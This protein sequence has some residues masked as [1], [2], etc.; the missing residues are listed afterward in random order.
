MVG[1]EAGDPLVS[2]KDGKKAGKQT[3]AGQEH[4]DTKA[5]KGS[6]TGGEELKNPVPPEKQEQNNYFAS[7]RL[8]RK[9]ARDSALSLLQDAASKEDAD[10]AVKKQVDSTIQ[11]M[12]D[13]TVTEAQIENLV[14][15]KGYTDC[16]AFIGEDTLSLAVHAPDG[17]LSAADTA[18]LV[19]AVTQ[20]SGF[21]AQQI[22][23]I[24]VPERG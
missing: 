19:D 3:G 16:V 4:Q 12:A 10:A 1:A 8:N 15:A 23:I 9:Q 17:G 11:T 20:S 5:A 21:K 22:K 13:C 24:E 14:L 6:K 7:A 18:K 2:K